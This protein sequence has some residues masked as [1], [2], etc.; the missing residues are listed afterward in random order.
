MISKKIVL[1]FPAGLIDKPIISTLAREYKLEFNIMKA[2]ITPDEEGLM[3]IEIS[4]DEKDFDKGI[5]YLGKEGV[6]IQS[7]S[8]DIKRNDTRCTNCG[9]CVTICPTQALVYDRETHEVHFYDTKCIACELCIKAC[10]VR[11]MTVK[12]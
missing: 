2:L 3:V 6:R 8:K 12:F 9:V 1:H 4:G 5:K 11:A 10:P 7:L